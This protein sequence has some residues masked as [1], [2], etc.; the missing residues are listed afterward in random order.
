MAPELYAFVLRTGG[1]AI[2]ATDGNPLRRAHPVLLRLVRQLI[3]K[4][5]LPPLTRE[6]L[7]TRAEYNKASGR[8]VLELAERVSGASAADIGRL[9]LDKIA[10]QAA[11]H[12]G[13]SALKA[14]LA[15]QQ[16]YPQALFPFQ[17]DTTLI[18]S[19]KWLAFSDQKESTLVVFSL[20]SCSHPFPFKS[21]SYRVAG[22]QSPSHLSKPDHDT[23]K[24]LRAAVVNEPARQELVEQDPSAKLAARTANVRFAPRFPDL[25]KKSVWKNKLLAEPGNAATTGT[26]GKAINQSAVGEA[27]SDQRVRSLELAVAIHESQERPPQPD[28]LMQTLSDLKALEGITVELLTASYDDGWTIPML[29]SCDQDGEVDSRLLVKDAQGMLQLRRTALFLIKKRTDFVVGA[30][31]DF[32]PAYTN[33]YFVMRNPLDIAADILP[34]LTKDFLEQAGLK[35]SLAELIA[36]V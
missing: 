26:P 33:I 11:L 22:L 23:P 35:R 31:V 24:T 12:V 25:T 15:S 3:T 5:C 16:A 19:G 13:T 7:Y 10:W 9:Y 18:A 20:K 29:P 17:G 8:L 1:S 36:R 30:V 32:E 14:S 4:L 6:A 34:Q 21:L 2:G 28:F 27:G